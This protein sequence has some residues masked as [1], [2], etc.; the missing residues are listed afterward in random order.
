MNDVVYLELFMVWNITLNQ[1]QGC[2]AIAKPR[3]KGNKPGQPS[4]CAHHSYGQMDDQ[5]LQTK[6]IKP[7]LPVEGSTW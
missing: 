5:S 3:T 7:T 4:K 1:N 6:P 2:L